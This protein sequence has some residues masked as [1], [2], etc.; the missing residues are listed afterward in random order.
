MGVG[1]THALI[2]TNAAHAAASFHLM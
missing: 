1:G 2:A